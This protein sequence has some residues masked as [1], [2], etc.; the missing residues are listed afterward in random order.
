V[1][2][3]TPGLLPHRLEELRQE[4]PILQR[5]TYLNSCSLGALSR[6]AEARLGEFTELWHDGGLG[7]VR[8]LAGTAGPT[9]GTGGRVPGRRGGRDRPLPST[10]VALSSIAESVDWRPGPGWSPRAGLPHPGLPVRREAGGGAGGAPERGRGDHPPRAVPGG[11]GRTHR[12][13]G[14]L[15]RLLHHRARQDLGALARIAREAGALSLIDG[16]QGA[17]QVA[18]D[19]TGRRGRL[20]HGPPQVALRGPGLAY[21]YVGRDRIRELRPRITSW[22]ATRIP[23]SSTWRV[24]L[25][26]RRPPLRD[27]DPGTSHGPH[28][29]GGTGD[30][31]RGGNGRIEARNRDLTRRLV[32]ELEGAGF[33]LRMASRPEERTA[34]VMVRHPDPPVPWTPWPGR[35]SSWITAPATSGSPPTSTTPGPSREG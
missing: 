6:R 12:L 5:K 16:Y 30:H 8:A 4:F 23:S 22:F 28:R 15:P 11:G 7:L 3:S 35:G 34:I 10:S 9:P 19:F 18:L 2:E 24:R 27:G 29:P 14:H 26:G 25:P 32:E 31:R 33:G 21:L 1:T 17:G 13:P 20:H